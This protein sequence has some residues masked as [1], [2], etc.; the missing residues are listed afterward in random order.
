MA[1]DGGR[2]LV[3]GYQ[4]RSHLRRGGG[5]GSRENRKEA[6][7]QG[8]RLVYCWSLSLSV[9]DT[10][11]RHG[12]IIPNGTE[13]GQPRGGGEDGIAHR[14]GPERDVRRP[15][16]LLGESSPG[17]EPAAAHRRCGG[18]AC[19][20]PQ[21]ADRQPSAERSRGPR[22]HPQGTSDNAPHAAAGRSGR[23]GTNFRRRCLSRSDVSALQWPRMRARRFGRRR[24][25]DDGEARPSGGRR[26]SGTRA[27]HRRRQPRRQFRRL[28]EQIVCGFPVLCD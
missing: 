25:R 11:K 7:G 20:P 3:G 21:P 8:N 6:P 9:L 28:S 1:R 26:L 4:R 15:A 2:L 19:A 13:A 17:A 24:G 10:V 16:R 27:P 18:A 14:T 5:N 23:A 22:H 12:H